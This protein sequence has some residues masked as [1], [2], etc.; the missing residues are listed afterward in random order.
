MYSYLLSLWPQLVEEVRDGDGSLLATLEKEFHKDRA[1]LVSELR[2]LLATT[3][4]VETFACEA[5]WILVP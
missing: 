3:S 1:S 2:K 5:S 4:N